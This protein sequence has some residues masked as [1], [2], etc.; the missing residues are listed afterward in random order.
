MLFE[1]PYNKLQNNTAVIWKR[2]TG[3]DPMALNTPLVKG[4]WTAIQHMVHL[5]KSER[6]FV[7]LLTKALRSNS[8]LEGSLWKIKIRSL[9]YKAYLNLGIKI[10]APKV[11]EP[12]DEV[13]ILEEVTKDFNKTRTQLYELLQSVNRDQAGKFWVH[14][15]YLKELRVKDLL[16]FMIFHQNHHYKTI[17]K[18]LK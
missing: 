3:Y 5:N 6:S 7:I 11:I 10:K 1:R 2:L 12:A 13:F 8:V 14:H 15:K 18:Y 16:D 4:K 9:F 17:R